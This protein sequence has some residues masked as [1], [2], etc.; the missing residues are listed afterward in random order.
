VSS[1]KTSYYDM[2]EAQH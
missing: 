1:S 2:E